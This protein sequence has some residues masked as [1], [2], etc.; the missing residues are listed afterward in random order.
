M[1][2]EIGARRVGPGQP[3]FAVAEIGLNHGGSLA[4]A[5]AMVA[6]AAGAGA[7]AVKLQT[8]RA[9][10]LVAPSCPP[11]A[12][13]SARSLVE[14]FHAFE[15]DEEAHAAVAREARWR[16]LAFMSTPF[17]IPA[18]DMLERVG[19]DAYKIA[20]G[21]ITFTGLLERVARTR[22]PIVI[23]TGMSDANDIAAALATVRQ[24]GGGPVALLHCVSSY[25]VPDDSQ[26]LGAISGLAERF[27]VVTGL[28]DHS[29]DPTAV[30]VAVALG[31]SI[32]EKHFMLQGQ[33]AIDAAV[34]A[35]PAEFS[36][37]V[38]AA[39]RARL[40]LGHGRKHCLA[41][42]ARNV[43]A[44]RRSVYAARDLRAGDTIGPDDLVLLR[45]A[46]GLD[47]NYASVLVGRP[48]LRDIP[49]GTPFYPAD[50]DRERERSC[51]HVA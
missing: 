2:L 6:A 1:Q 12:H 29:T 37:L 33:D 32:Y 7:S 34:S 3:L 44:S 36:R 49:A 45:P 48:V 21:D 31:A 13:V 25:P 19:C 26:N 39:E 22:K 16:G 5:L 42:E 20:S 40:A 46:I 28:S 24:H 38:R 23:S 18:V 4:D 35:D 10:T 41:A 47:P 30:V 51:S 17:D 14:F 43:V 50:L 8:L 9:A 15:L 11:P 27:G